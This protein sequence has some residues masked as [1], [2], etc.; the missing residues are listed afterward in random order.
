MP[1][2]NYLPTL[3]VQ[4]MHKMVIHGGVCETS[5]H[6][7]Q[8]HWIPQGPQLVKR[9]ISK[10]VTCRK[11]QAPPFRSEPT[12]PIPKSRVLQ[13][14]AFQLTGI[15]YAG[16]LY[17]R[18]IK[19]WTGNPVDQW[20]CQTNTCTCVREH[21]ERF[22]YLTIKYD[23]SS[24]RSVEYRSNENQKKLKIIFDGQLNNFLPI[25]YRL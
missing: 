8:T 20:R 3:I 24:L 7:R 5:T 18:P 19:N 13:S 9:I 2:D 4:S 22:S 15:D 23:A 25:S 10:C 21:G 1:K 6:I 17:V 11:L 16:P 14:Q 12:P